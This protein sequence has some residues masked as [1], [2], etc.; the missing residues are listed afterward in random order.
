MKM[1]PPTRMNSASSD[2]P[3][4]KPMRMAVAEFWKIMMITVAPS[5]PRPTVYIPATPPL[6]KATLSAPGSEPALAAAAVRTLPRT[7]RLIPM[8]PVRP[9]KKHP[10]MNASVRNSPDCAYDSASVPFGSTT[11]VEVTK[12]MAATG[13]TMMA[14]VLNCR[15]RYA[16]APT[17]IDLAISIIVGVPSSAAR[18]PWRST[19]PITMARMAVA[20]ETTS[21]AHSPPARL[22]TW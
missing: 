6:R 21:Q 4:P 17:W 9:D 10:P 11:L 22:K 16:I 13:M 7:A 20:A 8:K 2:P 5:R 3:N 1:P 15:R 18:T 19:K 14:I 12:T